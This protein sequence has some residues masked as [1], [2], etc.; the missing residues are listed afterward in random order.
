MCIRKY[1]CTVVFK[2]A[3]MY[4]CKHVSVLV[5]DG[6]MAVLTAIV[7]SDLISSCFTP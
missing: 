2:Y 3:A 5:H 1:I 7:V 6:T 4:V